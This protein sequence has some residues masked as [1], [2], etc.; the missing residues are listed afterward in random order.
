VNALT[1]PEA[2]FQMGFERVLGERMLVF[3]RR[4]PHLRAVLAQAKRW[5]DLEY[6]VFGDE[7]ITFG[8]LLRQV[9]A[10]ARAFDE[11][12]AVG[13]G[14]RVAILAA[15]CPEWIIAWWAAVSLGAVPVAMNAWWAGDEIA[16]ALD[17]C[18][19][20]LLIA[21]EKRL[22]RVARADMP[23]VSTGYD[24]SALRQFDAP[25]LPTV[26]LDEDDPAC[27]LYTSGTTGRPKGVVHSH[28][29]IIALSTL[30]LYHGARTAQKGP[31]QRCALVTN[32][33]FHVSGLYTQIVTFL[34][35]GSKTVWTR[36][37][38]VEVMRL[39]EREKVTGW[40]PHGPMGPRVFNHPDAGKYDLSSVLTLGTGGA[41][42]TP[43]VQAGLGRAFPNATLTVGYGL[44]ECTALATM[45]W[46]SELLAHPTSAG[47]PLPTVDLQIVDGEICIRS[48]LVMKEYFQRPDEKPFHPGRWLRTG[49]LGRIEDGRLYVES[50][51]RDLILRGAENVQPAEIEARLEQ[52]PAV[53]EAAVIGVDHPELGQE[54]KAV[55]VARGPVDTRALAEWVGATLAYYK[56]P[57]H[58]D[59]RTE[60]LPR[61]A[62]GKI[63]KRS[64]R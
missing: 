48:P 34:I 62:G 23:V 50:R 3:V 9:A 1:G 52:H 55:V 22:S 64:L 56:V 16:F 53:A 33:L 47:K 29:N 58:W 7:R 21:D 24:F 42:I 45:N 28:R 15:N 57:A 36:F 43:E 41:P 61:N 39:I 11:K 14:D 60:P 59:V 19:P 37:D 6:L 49:D 2:P 40:S 35:A 8:A 17:D 38:P 30:Q 46:G 26:P 4:D 63:M 18:R 27:I 44:T 31:K 54:V 13:K 5:R 32:P 25:A 51:K 12:F 20:A 10:V